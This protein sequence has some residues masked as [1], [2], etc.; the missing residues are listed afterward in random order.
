MKKKQQTKE[1]LSDWFPLIST[2]FQNPEPIRPAYSFL[3]VLPYPA[4]IIGN[5][6]GKSS[7]IVFLPHISS[8]VIFQR[9]FTMSPK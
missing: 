3:L 9:L 8:L 6:L 5:L 4:Y 2:F 1:L 7:H